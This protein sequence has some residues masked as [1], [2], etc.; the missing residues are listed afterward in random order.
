[1]FPCSS[2]FS[3]AP[4]SLQVLSSSLCFLLVGC[5]L[6]RSSSH[7]LCVLLDGLSCAK[8]RAQE[9][10]IGDGSCVDLCLEERIL[11]F[12]VRPAVL[13]NTIVIFVILLTMLSPLLMYILICRDV[14]IATEQYPVMVPFFL[15][16][17]AK[18]LSSQ[19][20]ERTPDEDPPSSRIEFL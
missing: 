12:M 9:S 13:V 7:C 11:I 8:P 1:M 14:R 4:C 20:S 16:F 5:V 10:C 17:V 19:S 15:F 18:G 2:M 6:H 3:P